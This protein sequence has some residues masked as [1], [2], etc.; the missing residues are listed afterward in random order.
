V[1]HLP[2]SKPESEPI[3]MATLPKRTQK[4]IDALKDA[5]WRLHP[6]AFPGNYRA[7]APCMDTD[8][9]TPDCIR[10]R[11][12]HMGQPIPG[13]SGP[14]PFDTYQPVRQVWF[15]VDQGGRVTHLETRT[16]VPW[17]GARSR[18]VSLPA[19]LAFVAAEED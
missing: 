11:L 9:P 14:Y 6:G 3:P 17:V 8:R 13:T 16:G 19:A 10:H 2:F 5:G 12:D 18:T 7:D 15:N 1:G 4:L